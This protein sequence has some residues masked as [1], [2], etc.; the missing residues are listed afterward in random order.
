MNLIQAVDVD[1]DHEDLV[2][3]AGLKG[4]KAPVPGLPIVKLKRII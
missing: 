3:E 2:D 4:G 1:F